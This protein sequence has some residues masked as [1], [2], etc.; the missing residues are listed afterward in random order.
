[1][2]LKFGYFTEEIKSISINKLSAVRIYMEAQKRGHQTYFFSPQDLFYE[3]GDMFARARNATF[4]PE[5]IERPQYELG[6]EEVIKVSDLDIFFMRKDPPI[7]N[8]YISF[9]YMLETLEGGKTVFINKPS[10][11][12][13]AHSKL[14]TLKYPDFIAPTMISSSKT[15]ILN[16]INKYGKAVIKPLDARG[17]QGILILEANDTNLNSLIDMMIAAYKGCVMIQKFLPEA[18][19]Q[20]DKRIILFDGEPVGAILRKAAEGDFRS[21]ISAGASFVRSEL[22][23]R[24]KEICEAIK[25]Y[26]QE[27]G[28]F[29]VGLDVIGGCITE[30]NATSP[31]MLAPANAAY[32][33]K[34][35][36]IFW[37]KL[38]AK[39]GYDTPA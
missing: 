8:F 9:T 23:E 22:T 17:G 18:V 3:E 2:T 38:E 32:G 31:G 35:E 36:E 13:N 33:I 14:L 5:K 28:L 10:A 27:N 15:E 24:E 20:G 21:N 25:P 29:F 30:I 7:D 11:I 37:D 4:F 1:M 26:L 34:F 16:F 12:R 19:T 39:L 6:E